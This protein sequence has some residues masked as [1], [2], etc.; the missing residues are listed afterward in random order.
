MA[1]FDKYPIVFFGNGSFKCEEVLFHPNAHFVNEINPSAAQ[2]IIPAFEKFKQQQFEDVAYF[3][4][5]Y[6]KDFVALKSK[7]SLF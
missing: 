2:M 6:L 3:E 5:F 4:P 1:L 7:K